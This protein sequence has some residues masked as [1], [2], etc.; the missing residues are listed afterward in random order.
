MRIWYQSIISPGRM[1][2]Y[3]R[4]LQQHAQSVA[5][6]G[7]EV[8]VH[9]TRT[10]GQA[11]QYRF[12]EFWD[13]RDVIENVLTAKQQGYDAFAIGNIVDP[14]LYEAREV[15]D[16]PALGLCEASLLVACMLG[17]NFS[18]IALNEKFVP[19]LEEKV[20]QYG[21]SS[22]LASVEYMHLVIPQVDGAF[23]DPARRDATIEQFLAGARKTIAQGAEVLIPAV[24]GVMALLAIAGVFE[25]DGVPIL[26]GVAALV[27]MTEMAVKLRQITGVTVSRRLLYAQPPAELAEL[28]RQ[29]YGV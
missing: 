27:K 8:L 10:G 28:A 29:A 22:R 15:L 6:P 19:R 23:H 5:D 24:G 7:T 18:L 12:Y 2:N 26:D 9:G 4:A 1:P 25:V 17:R 13:T 21:L 16:V 11:E 3:F 20:R 14:G